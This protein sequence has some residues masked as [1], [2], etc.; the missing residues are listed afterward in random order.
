MGS[1][2]TK[3]PKLRL[4]HSLQIRGKLRIDQITVLKPQTKAHTYHIRLYRTCVI[5]PQRPPQ[6]ECQDLHHVRSVTDHPSVFQGAANDVN[7]S[8]D[9]LT[10][11]IR[12]AGAILDFPNEQANINCK[13]W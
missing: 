13:G 9:F 1:L 11:Q 7:F 12:T 5:R 2:N 8:R 6:S 10:L 3:K 4:V